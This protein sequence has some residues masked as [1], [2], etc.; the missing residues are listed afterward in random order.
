MLKISLQEIVSR[1]KLY[2]EST[3]PC[4]VQARTVLEGCG[5]ESE[6]AWKTWVAATFGNW[7]MLFSQAFVALLVKFL[8]FLSLADELEPHAS[9]T[10]SFNP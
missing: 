4:G 7:A 8:E 1:C 2:N 9:Y 6:K 3:D 5:S 10:T